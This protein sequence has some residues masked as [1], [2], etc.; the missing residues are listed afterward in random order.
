MSLVVQ[1]EGGTMNLAKAAAGCILAAT[2]VTAQESG[3]HVRSIRVLATDPEAIATFYKK[4]F[5]MS[6]TRRP[7]DT[8][9]F[10]EIVLNSGST[11]TKPRWPAP[12]RS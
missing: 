6:E 8:A 7:A 3:V 5:G 11:P 2:M 10:K 4:T 9:T 1:N 12:R